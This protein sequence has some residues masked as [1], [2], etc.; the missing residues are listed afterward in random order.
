MLKSIQQYD[1]QYCKLLNIF[2]PYDT[3]PYKLDREIPKF[4]IVAYY[5]NLQHKFVYD[6]LFI[7][8]SQ[9]MACGTLKETEDA[10][11]TFREMRGMFDLF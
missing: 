8:K 4:D 10:S 2:N 5:S 11:Y 6:K 1:K 7:A 9:S 3:F